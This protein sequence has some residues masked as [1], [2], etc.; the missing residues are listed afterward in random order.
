MRHPYKREV[1]DLLLRL[2]C[3]LFK[4]VRVFDGDE[5]HKIKNREHA[6]ECIMAVDQ[7]WLSVKMPDGKV[8]T[9]MIIMGNSP[10]ELVSDWHMHDM[11][12]PVLQKFSD[13]WYSG[14]AIENMVD[15]LSDEVDTLIDERETT[16][17]LTL[18][19]L[20]YAHGQHEL[21]CGLLDVSPD[22]DAPG[23]TAYEAIVDIM[24]DGSTGG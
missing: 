22:P 15:S 6:L 1:E 5:K 7:A 19:Q 8:C 9:L 17:K 2:E 10:G 21:I 20:L 16:G 4:F 12:D 3:H 23:D 24:N 13:E 11:L 14:E 18:R